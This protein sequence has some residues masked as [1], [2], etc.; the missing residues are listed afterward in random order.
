MAGLYNVKRVIETKLMRV[1][2]NA[3]DSG[4]AGRAGADCS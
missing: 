3:D 4:E 1:N 2:L